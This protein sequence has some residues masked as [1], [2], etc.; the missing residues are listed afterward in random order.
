M[1]QTRPEM[2]ASSTN[3]CYIKMGEYIVYLEVSEA[4]DNEPQVKIGRSIGGT[5]KILLSAENT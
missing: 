4:T 1:K 3:S 5:I 2:T